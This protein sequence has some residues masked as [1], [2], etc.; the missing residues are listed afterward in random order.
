M[1][2]KG[3]NTNIVNNSWFDALN[4]RYDVHTHKL[5]NEAEDTIVLNSIDY[6]VI[7]GVIEV[8]NRL[9]LCT[10]TDT[11]DYILNFDGI[12]LYIIAQSEF[13]N[14]SIE[15]WI[16]G[17]YNS[18]SNNRE[19]II[20]WEDIKFDVNEPKIIDINSSNETLSESEVGV[21]NLMPN[22]NPLIISSYILPPKGK[23][24]VGKYTVALAYSIDDYILPISCY[25]EPINLYTTIS[26]TLGSAGISVQ[27]DR[28][29]ANKNKSGAISGKGLAL[30]LVEPLDTTFDGAYIYVFEY[31]E[32]TLTVYRS[33]ILYTTIDHISISD[34]SNYEIVDNS[35]I[36]P[37]IKLSKFQDAALYKNRLIVGN[38]DSDEVDNIILQ[39][40][41]NNVK[42]K[43]VSKYATVVFNDLHFLESRIPKDS[44]VAG[45]V[46]DIKIKFY[47]HGRVIPMVFTIPAKNLGL[48]YTAEVLTNMKYPI[49]FGTYANKPVA[50]HGIP[51]Y[52]TGDSTNAAFRKNVGTPGVSRYNGL[53]RY[54]L[55]VHNLD[56]PDNLGI[57]HYELVYTKRT[58]SN[59]RNIVYDMLV[60]NYDGKSHNT[61]SPGG[62][63]TTSYDRYLSS[64]HLDIFK[65][66]E[67][68]PFTPYKIVALYDIN[69]YG[70]AIPFPN[71]NSEFN[72]INSEYI[73]QSS[74]LYPDAEIIPDWLKGSVREDR[75][76]FM[77]NDVNDFIE[78][79]NNIGTP[80]TV[81][82]E[83]SNFLFCKLI[84]NTDSNLY[85]DY[86]FSEVIS[87][88]KIIPIRSIQEIYG[89]D[90][91]I[92]NYGTAILSRHEYTADVYTIE[93]D[94]NYL[95]SISIADTNMRYMGDTTLQEVYYP[96]AIVQLDGIADS[97]LNDHKNIRN[98]F[99]YNNEANFILPE[100]LEIYN[101]TESNTSDEFIIRFSNV[102]SFESN[103]IGVREF[104]A[105]NYIYSKSNLGGINGVI[106]TA[107]TMI[108]LH[109]YGIV[110]AK[111]SATL[112]SDTQLLQIQPINFSDLQLEEL[113][114]STGT[115]VGV[116]RN[117]DYVITDI[118][119]VLYSNSNKTVYLLND[120]L[121]NLNEIGIFKFLA[122]NLSMFD[123]S[124]A[125]VNPVLTYDFKSKSVIVTFK[126]KNDK[127][128]NL[129]YDL[130]LKA[131]IGKH[132]YTDF[133]YLAPIGQRLFGIGSNTDLNIVELH[134]SDIHK[135]GY[136]IFSFVYDKP[137]S[138]SSILGRIIETTIDKE[139]AIYPESIQI[140][141]RQGISEEIK[142]TAANYYDK[143]YSMHNGEFRVNKFNNIAKIGSPTIIGL[144][145]S[146]LKLTPENIENRWYKLKPFVA[147]EILVKISFD[148]KDEILIDDV[149]LLN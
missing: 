76:A 114:E 65:N 35:V 92:G 148:N 61:V 36:L 33:K 129:T 22:H 23:L 101:G 47:R 50:F 97:P 40:I 4:I 105:G 138:L 117:T 9:I 144:D 131:W 80:Q 78:A 84:G 149:K 27:Y 64:Q 124:D 134:N 115:S 39:N 13:F 74:N 98:W 91:K 20:F 82:Y 90:A 16:K 57:T 102:S 18:K 49:S 86:L 100:A 62:A 2:F 147:T 21:L 79:Y 94:Y 83:A 126:F 46:Y 136:I 14:F 1:E 139:E 113:L 143:N 85:R 103:N 137:T 24:K 81:I 71:L 128:L 77:S 122:S 17:L 30:D 29:S 41:A 63:I 106:T 10:T 145:G 38:T 60:M 72:S 19:Y 121:L 55:E 59:S 68:I 120:K 26:S 7:C 133:K 132:E 3:W 66:N 95:P 107:E 70:L 125:V 140:I 25:S 56:V 34:L 99:G 146:I 73:F 37:A 58:L 51:D 5:L 67:Y 6:G 89:F 123:N 108:I 28:H 87:T 118:G 52:G 141:T 11:T 116:E 45:E 110:M 109:Q 104:K 44:L 32:A 130:L 135:A 12:D 119:L 69:R 15:R 53:L 42:L 111:V 31:V 54:G 88:R 75:L 93:R 112:A 96:A 43:V 142:L 8:P 127:S 48:E